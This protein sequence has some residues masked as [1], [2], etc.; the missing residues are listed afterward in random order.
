M[1]DTALWSLL[2]GSALPPLVALVNRVAWPRPA[3]AAVAIA[4]SVLVGVLTAWLAGDLSG[5]S[6]AVGVLA[7]TTMALGTYQKMWKPSGI[8]DWLEM[9]Y[10]VGSLAGVGVDVLRRVAEANRDRP[11]PGGGVVLEP[12]E[13][14]PMTR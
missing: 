10:N 11:I 4:S 7:V 9:R 14:P 12:R 13:I 5:A 8:G 1:L 3:K 2:A 6:L